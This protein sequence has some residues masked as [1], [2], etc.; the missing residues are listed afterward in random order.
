MFK[1]EILKIR[2]DFSD[3]LIYGSSYM[4][5]KE[6]V[7]SE[8]DKIFELDFFDGTTLIEIKKHYTE[9]QAGGESIEFECETNDCIYG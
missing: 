2:E 3:G 4:L 7:L 1:T 5:S 8:Y 6:K 9:L